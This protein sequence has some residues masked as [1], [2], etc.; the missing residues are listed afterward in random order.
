[1]T[2]PLILTSPKGKAI[3]PHL[4]E[5][6]TKYKAEGEYHVKLECNKSEGQNII[7]L[8]GSEIAKKVKEQHDLD[9]KKPITKAPL[10]YV[11]VNDKVVFNFKMKASGIRKSDGKHFTQKPV[12]VNADLSPVEP[13]M[14]ICGD[15]ILKIT[16]EPYAWNMPIG[17]GCTLRIKAV[18]VLELVTGKSSNTLGE[19]K[20]EPIVAPKVKEEVSE[21]VFLP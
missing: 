4:T 7:A 8:I 13:D 20:A 5:P 2:K 19:L 11:E 12:L 17:I 10:P 18:Q 15:S 21:G 9:P 16:F 3:F 1:M 6:D 14:Q